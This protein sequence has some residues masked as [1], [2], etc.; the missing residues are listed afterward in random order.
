MR[1]HG[2]CATV[3][4]NTLW[5]PSQ[6]QICLP[7]CSLILCVSQVAGQPAGD[8]ALQQVGGCTH[9]C[10][11]LRAWQGWQRVFGNAQLQRLTRHVAMDQHR[12]RQQRAV[13]CLA[14]LE[15]RRRHRGSHVHRDFACERHRPRAA[16]ACVAPCRAGCCATAPGLSSSESRARKLNESIRTPSDVTQS[17]ALRRQPLTPTR[18]TSDAWETHPR[19]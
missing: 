11:R 15:G 14:A 12:G 18:R 19:E 17:Q 7:L 4:A 5:V 1:Q 10:H 3:S 8:D 13:S 9:A 6:G 16:V 2:K